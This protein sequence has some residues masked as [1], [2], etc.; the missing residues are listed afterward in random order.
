MRAILV[1][2][3]Y[4]FGE[5]ALPPPQIHPRFVVKVIIF[6]NRLHNCA[7]VNDP[8]KFFLSHRQMAATNEVRRNKH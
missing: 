6:H 2:L 5:V 3:F 8:L 1:C 4:Y 7:L